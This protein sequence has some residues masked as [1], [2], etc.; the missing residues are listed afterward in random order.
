MTP[1]EAIRERVKWDFGSWWFIHGGS[2]HGLW[3][4]KDYSAI[5]DLAMS[6]P[7]EASKHEHE[8]LMPIIEGL[9]AVVEMQQEALRRYTGRKLEFNEG[10]GGTLLYNGNEG[11]KMPF[12][13]GETWE[14]G[15][16]A[17]EISELVQAT[18]E[19][20]GKGGI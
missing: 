16:H 2:I 20:I 4:R 7:R 5:R 6:L 15:S 13:Q 8:K 18:L 14:Y 17:E 12:F 11:P 19:K 10:G 1:T 9:L 3:K